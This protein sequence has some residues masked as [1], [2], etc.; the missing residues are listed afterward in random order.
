MLV[1]FMWGPFFCSKKCELPPAT[2]LRYLG[3]E[4]GS[5][6]ISF[7]VPQDKLDQLHLLL[8]SALDTGLDAGEL[9]HSTLQRSAGK[10]MSMTIAIRPASLG[11]HAM[12][13]KLAVMDKA[14]LRFVDLRRDANAD[15]LGESKQSLSLAATSNEGLWQRALHLIVKLD[16]SS[17]ASTL[18]WRGFINIVSTPCRA[19]GTFSNDWLLKDINKKYMFSLYHPSTAI[20]RPVCYRPPACTS[21]I[22]VDN[23]AAVGGFNGGRARG[24]ETHALLVS[25]SVASLGR[26]SYFVTQMDS[27]GC[28]RGHRCHFTPVG[29]VYFTTSVAGFLVVVGGVFPV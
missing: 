22:D 5:S 6:S 21:A 2:V 24:P 4:C 17:D 28:K 20:L 29:I 15:L 10:C 13:T 14:G 8:Q 26:V 19:I 27:V 11:T 12:F 16:D 9:S 18:G 23:S 25:S 3:T 7:R 1:S